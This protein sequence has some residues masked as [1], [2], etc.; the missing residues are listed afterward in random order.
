MGIMNTLLGGTD[1]SDGQTLYAGSLNDTFDALVL[2]RKVHSIA[3]EDTST[4][5]TWADM[6]DGTFTITNGL[7]SLIVGINIGVDLKISNGSY[8]AETGLKIVGSNLG[9]KYFVTLDNWLVN[10]G[11]DGDTFS[12]RLETSEAYLFQALD[13]GYKQFTASAFYPLKLLD[14][15]TTFSIRLRTNNASG[16]AYIQNAKVEIIYI[17]NFVDD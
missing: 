3:T 12:P 6:T 14:A 16:T 17:K 2:H 4:S 5:I 1:W 7:N 13:T 11:V 10:A 8:R 9:T 15:T